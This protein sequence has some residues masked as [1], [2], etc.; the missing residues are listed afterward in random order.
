MF[1]NPIV[2]EMGVPEPEGIPVPW[3][4]RAFPLKC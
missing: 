2:P 3:S 1:A 4:V